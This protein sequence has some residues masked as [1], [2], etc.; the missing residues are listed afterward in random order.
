MEKFYQTILTYI[1]KRPLLE[2]I[3]LWVVKYSPYI[4]MA[5]YPC[6]IIYLLI[7]QSPLLIKV[8]Y[9]PLGAFLVV[10]IIRKL[11]N[12]P[13]PYETLNI[14]PLV[15]HKKGESFPSRHAVSS[16]IIG[17]VCF[18]VSPILGI[19]GVIVATIVCL[20]RIIAGV[21]YISDVLTA[22]AIAV[23]FYMI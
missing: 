18:Y 14:E 23:L 4:T 16:V 20:S 21:H 2:K 6:I 11:V 13:R 15:S 17:L 10:T 9:K 22:I 19:F 5:I 7:I 3:L 12:R 8:L 1:R